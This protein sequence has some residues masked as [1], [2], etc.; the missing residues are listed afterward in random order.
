M[1]R[2]THYD[3]LGIPFNAS[4]EEIKRA[5]RRLAKEHHPDSA[6]HSDSDR[7]RR[8]QEAYETLLDDDARRRYD[9]ELRTGRQSRRRGTG[10]ARTG[11]EWRSPGSTAGGG[12]W[13]PSRSGPRQRGGTPDEEFATFGFGERTRGFSSFG[14]F[15]G[16]ESL[17]SLL[18]RFVHG[19]SGAPSSRA[20]FDL[21]LSPQEAAEGVTVPIDVAEFIPA[22]GRN[23][24]VRFEVPGNR[25]TGDILTG[26]IP[27][28]WGRQFEIEFR[29]IVR[30]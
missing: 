23:D 14:D 15:G 16:F 19:L 21:V 12:P 18:R 28:E 22:A 1:S 25:Q 6:S 20:S 5:Y 13:G 7:F 3:V 26:S 10:S 4:K 8:A 17:D 29:V 30:G 24:E 9:R 27:G 2:E 11:P